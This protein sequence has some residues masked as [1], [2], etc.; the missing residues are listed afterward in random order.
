MAAFLLGL[1]VL[2]LVLFALN[3]F[4]NANPA[5]LVRMRARRAVS[6]C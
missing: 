1:L 4:A 3:A 2:V 6:R 5:S